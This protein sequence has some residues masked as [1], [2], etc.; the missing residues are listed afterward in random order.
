M[1]RN[2]ALITFLLL[3]G[4]VW[5]TSCDKDVKEFV[6]LFV[7]ASDSPTFSRLDN[8]GNPTSPAPGHQAVSPLNVNKIAINYI[9]LVPFDTTGYKEGVIIYKTPETYGGG[10]LAIHFDS[11]LMTSPGDDFFNVNLKK[12]PPGLYSYIRISVAYMSYD[13]PLNIAAFPV[14]GDIEN[15][16]ATFA[17]L[18]GFRTYASTITPL[19]ISKEINANKERGYWL[20]ETQIASPNDTLNSIYSWQLE[21]ESITSVNILAGS[22]PIPSN[23]GVITGMLPTPM[24]V[25]E[26]D[27]RDIR[28]HLGLSTNGI[29]EWNDI[30]GN[31][32]WDFHAGDIYLS[33]P[34]ID[35][36]VRGLVPTFEYIN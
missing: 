34:L 24:E 20:L 12:I 11:L 35:F 23:Q 7:E 32:V 8:S 5:I 2:K 28:I 16:R 1:M 3:T 30:N 18:L 4:S 25:L 9:E 27:T 36:G 26:D 31:G 13:I 33:E 29:F 17:C 21:S 10:E 15:T 6:T 14:L 22:A 19:L